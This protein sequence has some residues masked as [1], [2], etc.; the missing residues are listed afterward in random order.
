M[1]HRQR[2]RVAFRVKV[3]AIAKAKAHH[4]TQWRESRALPRAERYAARR[5]ANQEYRATKLRIRR[6][7][8]VAAARIGQFITTQYY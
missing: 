3:E 4:R 7:F 6:E 5:A 8:R 1:T 2:L